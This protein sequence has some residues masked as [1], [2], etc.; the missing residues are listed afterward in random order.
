MRVTATVATTG[1][2]L[3]SIDRAARRPMSAKEGKYE[4]YKTSQRFDAT[5]THPQWLG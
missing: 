1:D 2:V 5:Y 3:R 4:L